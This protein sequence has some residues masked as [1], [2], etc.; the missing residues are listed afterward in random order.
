M[1][2]ALDYKAMLAVALA[3]LR[4]SNRYSDRRSAL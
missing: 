3:G 4:R 1:D 2:F